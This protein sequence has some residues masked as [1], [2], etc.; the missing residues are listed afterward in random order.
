MSSAVRVPLLQQYYQ[1]FLLDQDSAQY[2]ERVHRKY[3]LG[4]LERLA[5]A[6]QRITR[7]A[8]VL[9]LGFLGEYSSNGVLG[10]ALIDTDR[11]VRLLAD[12]GIRSLW[13]RDGN[14]DDRRRLATLVRLNTAH[15]Y[16]ESIRRATDL[17]DRSPAVAEAWNQRAI[18][19]FN[20]GRFAESIQDCRQALELNPYHFGAAAGMGQCYL[21]LR[22]QVSALESFRRALRLNPGLEGVRAQVAQL[23]RALQNREEGRSPGE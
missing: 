16:E 7:R 8:A 15:R 13:C 22:D 5:Q 14:A 2:V 12:N 21:Q 23:Q 18:A 19:L 1:Q 11:G 10:R 20:T 9:A 3:A 6:G 4:T 17:V